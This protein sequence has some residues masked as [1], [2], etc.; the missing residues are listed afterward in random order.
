MASFD[1]SVFSNAYLDIENEQCK[2][3]Q[4]IAYGP[5]VTHIYSPVHYAAR[6]HELFVRKFCTG[7]KEV[8]F[9]GMNPGPFGMAQNGVPFGDTEY[10][11]NWMHIEGEVGRPEKEHPKRRILGLNCTRSEVSGQR[12]WGLFSSLCP[13][14]EMFFAHCF[15]HN[16]CPLAFL[17]SSGANITPNKLPLQARHQLHTTCNGA[18]LR[19]VTLLQP[20]LV[21]GIGCYARDRALSALKDSSQE[22]IT[23]EVQVAAMTHPS[24]ASPRANSGWKDLAFEE[25]KTLGVLAYLTGR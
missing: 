9:L 13:S 22:G 24:P 19:V 14:P 11:R 10:V 4:T 16:Y 25:L 1:S 2:Q 12:F 17:A 15:V 23:W 18:F 21:I 6:T 8:L 5:T 3:L 20:R 7:T